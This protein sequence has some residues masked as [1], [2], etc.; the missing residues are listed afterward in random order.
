MRAARPSLGTIR[1][2]FS[3]PTRWS[4]S[5]KLPRWRRGGGGG[6]RRGGAGRGGRPRRGRV[7][8]RS[9]I[10]RRRHA[11]RRH[12][13]AARDLRAPG[14]RRGRGALEPTEPVPPAP[15]LRAR[16]PLPHRSRRQRWI[17]VLP[18]ERLRGDAVVRAAVGRGERR[19]GPPVAPSEAWLWLKSPNRMD[20]SSGSR[21][22]SSGLTRACSRRRWRRLQRRRT[23]A[24]ASSL[25][26]NSSPWS[27][28]EWFLPNEPLV[29]SDGIEPRLV[30]LRG[31]QQSDVGQTADAGLCVSRRRY[32]HVP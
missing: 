30:D 31:A 21:M 5:P 14:L 1:P 29:E 4:R 6:C 32:I 13:A 12:G 15:P 23:R 11:R 20:V 26:F 3:E 2:A 24:P 16:V 9:D 8:R 17:Q 7:T 25:G 10:G 22:G 27:E 18:S 19:R 28:D